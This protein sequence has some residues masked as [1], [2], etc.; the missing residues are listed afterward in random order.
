MI[1]PADFLA[2]PLACTSG[3]TVSLPIAMDSM[4]TGSFCLTNVCDRTLTKK[5]ASSS[6]APV[7]AGAKYKWTVFHVKFRAAILPA[8]PQP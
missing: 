7:L 6:A 4:A 1:K 2:Y 5:N 8:S 3:Q